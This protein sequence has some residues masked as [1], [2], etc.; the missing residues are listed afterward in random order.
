MWKKPKLVTAL[1]VLGLVAGICLAQRTPR[2]LASHSTE[3]PMWTNSA[4]FQKDVFTFVRLKYTVD[5]RHGFGHTKDRWLIDSPDSDLDFSFRLQQMTSM[6]V[7]PD[8]LYLDITDK[9]LFN[10]PFTYIVEPGRLTFTDEEVT[11]LRKY[12][13][14]GGFLMFDDFWGEREYAAFYEEIKKV[15]PNR[16]PVELPF[17]HPIFHC[18]FDLDKK[19]QIPGIEHALKNQGTDITWEPRRGEDTSEVHYKGIFDDKNRLMVLIC[20]NTDLGD[21]WEREG[22]NEYYFK[23]FSEKYGYPLGINIVFYVMTH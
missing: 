18:V 19:P 9:E 15:F 17:E 3:T 21:S 4:A 7:N 20:H 6:K 13:S 22:E 12:L 5:G 14:N 23:R 2:E 10:Y 16:E 8:G 1:L 11:I